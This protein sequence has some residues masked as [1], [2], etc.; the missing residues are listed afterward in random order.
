MAA[1]ATPRDY[2]AAIIAEVSRR[3]RL[4]DLVTRA[5][6]HKAPVDGGWVRRADVTRAV[7]ALCDREAGPG[8]ALG[9]EL[10]RVLLEA[11]WRERRYHGTWQWRATFKLPKPPPAPKKPR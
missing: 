8:F 1:A 7:G 3:D 5:G 10:R 6:F 4:L 11:G 9:V 2:L